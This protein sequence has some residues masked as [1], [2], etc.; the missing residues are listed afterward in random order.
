MIRLKCEKTAQHGVEE[1]RLG[2][3]DVV[4]VVLVTRRRSAI[5]QRSAQRSDNICEPVEMK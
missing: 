2:V 5:E 1:A 4:P 3:K